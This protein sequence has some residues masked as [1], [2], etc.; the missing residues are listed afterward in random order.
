LITWESLAADT[1]VFDDKLWTGLEAYPC[2]V[3]LSWSEQTLAADSGA[4]YVF[5][6]AMGLE[7]WG[8]FVLWWV[9]FAAVDQEEM[10]WSSH[11]DSSIINISHHYIDVMAILLALPYMGDARLVPDMF[12]EKRELFELVTLHLVAA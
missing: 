5:V 7:L 2:V 6:A 3:W 10:S 1:N 8:V 4:V 11:Q 12:I 9:N